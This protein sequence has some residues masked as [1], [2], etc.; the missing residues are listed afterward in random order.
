[1]KTFFFHVYSHPSHSFPLMFENNFCLLHVRSLFLKASNPINLFNLFQFTTFGC[2]VDI[3]LG[4]SLAKF[5]QLLKTVENGIF[6]HV[7]F[8][9]SLARDN[10]SDFHLYINMLFIYNLALAGICF[11]G[12]RWRL[13]E[14]NQIRYVCK[15]R[16]ISKIWKSQRCKKV[17][18]Q[19]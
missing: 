13:I 5:G 1:M 9:R 4:L 17:H 2:I 14:I 6:L 18:E 11:P 19:K 7:S 3:T 12:R 8:T 10:R 16:N 15:I